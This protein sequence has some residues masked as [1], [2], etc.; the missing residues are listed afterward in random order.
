VRWINIQASSLSAP[1]IV[2]GRSHLDSRVAARR[3][4]LGLSAAA[5]VP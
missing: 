2:T 1:L 3:W 4:R 5:S